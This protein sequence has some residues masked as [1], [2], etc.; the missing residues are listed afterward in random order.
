MPTNAELV[1]HVRSLAR[2]TIPPDVAV[3]LAQEKE[4]RARDASML[5]EMFVRA[6]DSDAKRR[7]AETAAD[8]LAQ[9]VATL[10]SELRELRARGTGTAPAVA[11]AGEARARALEQRLR[12]TDEKLRVAEDQQRTA[13]ERARSVQ[14]IA[15]VLEQAARA[16]KDESA[17]MG[18]RIELLELELGRARTQ[19]AEVAESAA[20]LARRVEELSAAA[21]RAVEV[22]GLRAQLSTIERELAALKDEHTRAVMRAT[23]AE[24]RVEELAGQL[25]EI[26]QRASSAEWNAERSAS[27]LETATKRSAGL[28]A[29]LARLMKR[30]TEL[31]RDHLKLRRSEGEATQQATSLRTQLEG[32][33]ATAEGTRTELEHVVA[34]LGAN[35][36]A[37]RAYSET[38][39]T[40]SAALAELDLEEGRIAEARR[41][42]LADVAGLLARADLVAAAVPDAPLVARTTPKVVDPP[43]VGEP[44]VS[45]KGGASAG[46]P[47][48]TVS[49]ARARSPASPRA[50]R[51]SMTN[52]PGLA[53]D[54][55]A[56]DDD[57]TEVHRRKS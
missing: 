4:A 26:E 24:T 43:A 41:K 57:P 45:V 27:D 2:Q 8:A 30:T 5:G 52:L 28:E 18:Q 39:A 44:R 31:E 47:E 37:L 29:E 22:E 3:E 15:G 32:A 17:S 51:S 53:R 49:S 20:V 56:N 34:G 25:N 33:R 6:C 23:V 12:S 40:V 19:R 11:E 21:Q 35:R 16:S 55:R 46:D 7:M 42:T 36:A 54:Q 50:A 14:H 9:R 38:T 1:S 10:E 48:V 13:E